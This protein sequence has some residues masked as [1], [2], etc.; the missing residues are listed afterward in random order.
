VVRFALR[1]LGVLAVAF[2][3]AVVAP[4]QRVERSR[5]PG[6]GIAP[7]GERDSAPAIRTGA[8]LGRRLAHSLPLALPPAASALQAPD[9]TAVIRFARCADPIVRARTRARGA[10]APPPSA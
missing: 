1:G 7:A 3:V 9:L 4:V 8:D 2:G 10:R 5:D 6:S